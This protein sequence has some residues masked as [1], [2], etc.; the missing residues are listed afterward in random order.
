VV[1]PTRGPPAFGCSGGPPAVAEAQM[2]EANASDARFWWEKGIRVPAFSIDG[3][4][5]SAVRV[6]DSK[7][8]F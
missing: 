2:K 5:P 4:E 1:R 6:L 8:R 7:Q 3:S